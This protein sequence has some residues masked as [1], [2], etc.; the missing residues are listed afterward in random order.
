[1]VAALPEGTAAVVVAS[2]A[3]LAAS[4]SLDVPVDQWVNHGDARA[5]FICSG[6]VRSWW[7]AINA[8]RSFQPD[9]VYVNSYFDYQFSLIPRILVRLGVFRRARVLLAPRGEF[10]PGALAMHRWRKRLALTLSR[11]V[12][13]DKGV[14]WHASAQ[15]ERDDIRRVIGSRADVVIRQNDTDLPPVPAEPPDRGAGPLR[16]IHVSRLSPKKGL[17]VLLTAL[18]GVEAPTALDIYGPVEDRRFVNRCQ[19]L[20]QTLPAHITVK[21]CGAL[22]RDRVRPTLAAYDVMTLATRGENFGHV[23]AEALS[24]SCPVMCPDKTPW[25]EWL[26]AGGGVVV[27]PDTAGQWTRTI[28]EYARLSP[29]ELQARRHSAGKAYADWHRTTTSQPHLF[30]LMRGRRTL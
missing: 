17:D 29:D 19:E 28:D 4:S 15:G 10:S 23:I 12:G 1:M 3:D 26:R 7:K 9:V 2:N 6:S 25:T 24:V 21:F 5:R 14:T 18:R 11:L 22:E 30:T 8:V 13:L 27:D 20:A 16:A